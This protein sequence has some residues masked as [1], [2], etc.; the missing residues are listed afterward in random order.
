VKLKA[1]LATT[2]TASRAERSDSVR[3]APT[4]SSSHETKGSGAPSKTTRRARLVAAVA[5]VV[6]GVL[7]AGSGDALATT[8]HTFAGSFGGTGEGEGEFGPKPMGVGV[9]L[10]GEVFTTDFDFRIQRFDATGVF[11]AFIPPQFGGINES[12]AVAV[13]SS[14]AGG[15]YVAEIAGPGVVAKYTPAGAFQYA[16]DASTSETTINR[17]PIVAVD[18]SN[19]TVYVTAT[20]NNTGAPVID[21]FSQTTGA[22]IASFDGSNGSPDGGLACPA[23]LAVDP[24][25]SVYVFDPC[26]GRVDKYSAAGAYEATVDD[27]SRGAPQA[28]A[29]DPKTGELY[30]AESG[31]SGLQITNFSAGGASVI[32]T[33]AAPN[34]TSLVAMA[35]GPDGTLYVA[36]GEFF[37]NSVIDRFTSFVGPTVTTAAP[38]EI[39]RTA[40]TFNGT[41]D[42]GGVASKYHYE[43]GLENTYGSSTE[44]IDAGS[45]SGAIEA[46]GP[47]T[48]LIPNTTYHYRVVGSNA[49][50]SIVGVDE[51]LT[52]LA[53][54]PTV[55]GSH[56]FVS[57]ITPTGARIHATVNPQHSATTFRIEYGTTIAYGSSTPEG[58]AEVG[59]QS[60]DQA[61]AATLTGLQP[62]TLYH[63]RVSAE[64]GV[65]GPQTGADATFITAPAAPASGSEVTTR[66]AT[67]TGTIDP[68]GAATTYH[69]NYG[70]STA[71]G[72][73]TAEADAA[74]GNGEQ[75][76]TAPV[77]G[78]APSTTYHVQVVATTNG[79]TRS[80]A[81]GSFTTA[82]AATAT[83]SDPIA[84]TTSSA[85]L[86]GA[87]DTHGLAGNYHF[88]VTAAEGSFASGTAEQPLAAVTGAQPV[89]TPVSGLPSGQG[90]Q[91]RLVVT[92]NEATDVSDPA[93]FTTALSPPENF[94]GPPPS[95]SIYGCVAP[96]LNPVTGK[97]KPGSTIT[98]TGSD[99]G[100]IGR[101][102]L[103]EDT[104]I[105]TGWS[106]TGFTIEVPADA[107][108]TLGLTVNCG[109][110]S[111][112]VA[113][114]TTGEPNNT[115]SIGRATVKRTIATVSVTLPGPGKLEIFGAR[116]RA[117]TT[118]V[119]KAGTRT[120]RVA[121][122]GAGVKG[123]RKAKRRT[124][125]VK[126]QLRFTPTGGQ[127]AIR[128]A[129]LTFKRNGGH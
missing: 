117:A 16:L 121:L 72:A 93:F 61:V 102:L 111:N 108:G 29:T 83:I 62:D 36:N 114:A 35:V 23:G 124:L 13:D 74:S 98:V 1:T 25:H 28:I 91:V 57:A 105:P 71:Y 85:T 42:P 45:G 125:A 76:V 9:G 63:Y 31:V 39:E 37:V 66:K 32:Y 129:A 41:I 78:L 68:H 79:V 99:L 94:P 100:L 87:A 118:T 115:F 90:L 17:S 5:V 82:P 10:S 34:V 81:D 26:K 110:A 40:A 27:G 30:V 70:P 126:V 49:S 20:N 44:P 22:F 104:L 92:S 48:G 80:G 69:F 21:S 89:A 47:V 14:L 64:D 56:A 11:Q 96:K 8:G 33:F 51:T 95:A 58:G 128:T 6:V 123:L 84:V 12:G 59:E 50:G 86:R 7:L 53:A 127:P 52:T 55:D 43:Y 2:L 4:L 75:Q 113:V 3:A 65:E 88:E 103:G 46:P 38:G 122:S 77:S 107:T 54:P 60:S 116:T 15:V 119:A 18:P 101:V 109:V 106:A 73:S 112:T 120:V 24:S 19:G 67:L 97:I